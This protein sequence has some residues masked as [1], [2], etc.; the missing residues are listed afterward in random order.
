VPDARLKE[1]RIDGPKQSR[2]Y[3]RFAIALGQSVMD[4]ARANKATCFTGSYYGMNVCFGGRDSVLRARGGTTWGNTFYSASKS[5]PRLQPL[6]FRNLMAHEGVHYRQWEMYGPDFMSLYLTAQANESYPIL[7]GFGREGC[8]N[9]FEREANLRG[10][11]V[12]GCS[13]R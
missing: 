3:A 11:N 4:E 2:K 12:Y 9:R 1:I 13:I 5:D 10:Y 7:Q 8:Y 6:A